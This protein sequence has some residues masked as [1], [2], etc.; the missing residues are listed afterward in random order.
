M[1]S[2]H[3]VQIPHPLPFG[4][5]LRGGPLLFEGQ[6]RVLLCPENVP[7]LIDRFLPPV[8]SHFE[9]AHPLNTFRASG[10]RKKPSLTLSL[11]LLVPHSLT[12]Q[13]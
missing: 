12:V 5:P 3:P 4:R 6:R 9:I 11:S 2:K 1:P 13:G 10:G 7:Y 8:E